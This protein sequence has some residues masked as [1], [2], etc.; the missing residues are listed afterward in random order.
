MED[1][2]NNV[3]IVSYAIAIKNKNINEIENLINNDKKYNEKTVLLE[4]YN[5]SLLTREGLQF[6]IENCYQYFNITTTLI[7]KLMKDNNVGLLDII[8]N[9]LKFFDNETIMN[10]LL[11]HKNKTPISTKDLNQQI[12]NEK[13]KI[14]THTTYSN[15]SDKYLFN[16]CN[17]GN[18]TIV[19]RLVKYGVD[20]NSVHNEV[21]TGSTPFFYAGKSGNL[22]LV[23]YLIKLGADI[24]KENKKGET[25][26]FSS[27][28]SGNEDLVKY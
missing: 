27:C 11:Y 19:K 10:F 1:L 4:L 23:K 8:F 25:I 16:A 12:S 22:S 17:S 6:I 7:K 2:T 20:I 5:K 3:N 26:I 9:H 21:Y 13:N 28:E 24:H 14:L 18:E 15:N